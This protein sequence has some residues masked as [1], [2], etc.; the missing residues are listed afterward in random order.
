VK[1]FSISPVLIVVAAVAFARVGLLAP[2]HQA[3]AGRPKANKS[4][5]VGDHRKPP[6]RSVR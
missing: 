3:E 6:R 5:V 2:L 1:T 4:P